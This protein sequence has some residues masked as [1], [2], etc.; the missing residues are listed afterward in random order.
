LN[1]TV[2][3]AGIACVTG[4]IVGGGLKAFGIEI[5]ALSSFKRQLILIAFGLILIYVYCQ[6]SPDQQNADVWTDSGN[7]MWPKSSTYVASSLADAKQYCANST[8]GGY[9]DWVVPNYD[10]LHN[11][12]GGFVANPFSHIHIASTHVW[13]TPEPGPPYAPGSDLK[14]DHSV[15]YDTTLDT[16]EEDQSVVERTIAVCVRK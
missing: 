9:V 2:L 7:I 15:K 4:G 11:H 12:V 1:T 16:F 13:M 10:P 3:S 8:V 6:S 14:F 5:P